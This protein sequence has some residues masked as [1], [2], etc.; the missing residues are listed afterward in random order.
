[1]LSVGQRVFA[2]NGSGGNWSQYAVVP[3]QTAWPVPNDIPDA[4][5]ASLMINP[6]TA[7]LMV[8][9]VL[10]VPRGEWLLQ[11][12]AGSELGRMII[13]L[14][15]HDGIRT[16]NVSASRGRAGARGARRGRGDRVQ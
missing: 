4:Q 10:A 7:I 8:R 13:R 14:A 3:A 15:K 5:V 16:I 9:H 6:A 11:S 2:H 12:A 1:M